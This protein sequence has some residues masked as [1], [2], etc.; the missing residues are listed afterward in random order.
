MGKF[1]DIRFGSDFLDVIPKAQITKEK[2]DKLD[3]RF[4]LHKSFVH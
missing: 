1:H 2:I 3:F 4:G